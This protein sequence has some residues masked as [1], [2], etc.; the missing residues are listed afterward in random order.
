M[1]LSMF[2]SRQALIISAVAAAICVTLGC[3]LQ[4]AMKNRRRKFAEPIIYVGYLFLAA[5][6][7]IYIVL[8]FSS[9]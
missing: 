7:A 9:P 4:L 8:G 6:V 5:S 1:I 3:V 2:L